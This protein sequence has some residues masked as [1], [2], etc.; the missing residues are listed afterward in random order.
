MENRAHAL[1]AGVFVLLLAVAAVGAVLW[2]SGADDKTRDYTVVVSRGNVTGLNP[3]ARVNYRGIK[4]GKVVDVRLDPNNPRDILVGIRV[5][6]SVPV[7]RGT[8]AK[9]GYQGI[10]GLAHVL[11]E[12]SGKDPR[13]LVD[14][15]GEPPRIALQASLFDELTDAGGSL[16]KQAGE[17]LTRAN[18]VLDPDN[19]QHLGKTLANLERTTE[20][21]AGATAALPETMARMQRLL[22]EENVRRFE[23]SLDGAALA[24]ENAAATLGEWRRLAGELSAVSQQVGAAVGSPGGD[25]IAAAGPKINALANDLAA[26]SRQVDRLLRVLE[27]SPQSVVFGAPA[28]RPGPGEAGFTIPP[29]KTP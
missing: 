4:V 19:R 28:G 26:T 11:L 23:R 21:L 18:A 10:T 16:V 1:I 14:N 24:T 5:S 9:L 27:E 12:D 13:P 22:S 2:F 7:T 17:F 3:Q 20:Q 8:T 25:G 6:T 29:R 15:D